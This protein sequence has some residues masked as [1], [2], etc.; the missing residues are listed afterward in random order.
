[1]ATEVSNKDDCKID[2]SS[3]LNSRAAEEEDFP[4][5]GASAL[6][7]LEVRKIRNEAEKDVLFG[8][9]SLNSES[10]PTVK[11]KTKKAKKTVETKKAK[12]DDQPEFLEKPRQ[13]LVES[14]TFKKLYKGMKVLG[15]IKEVNEFDLAI[16]LPN[17]LTGFVSI[18]D[19]NDK[20]TEKLQEELQAKNSED[21]EAYFLELSM[22]FKVGSLVQCSVLKHEVST[23]GHQ[24]IELSLNPKEVNNGLTKLSLKQGMVLQGYVSSVE[25]HGYLISFDIE[26]IKAFLAKKDLSQELKEGHPLCVVIK[27]VAEKN[28]IITVSIDNKE[29]QV[30]MMKEDKSLKFSALLPGMLV[31]A[32]VTQV[33][34]NGLLLNFLGGFEGSADICH[35]PKCGGDGQNLA[36]S[37]PVKAKFKCRL[38]YIN[39][40]TKMAGLSLQGNIIQNQATDFGDFSVGDVVD[41]VTVIRVDQGLGLLMKLSDSVVGFTHI[42]RVSDGHVEK[43]GKEYKVGST[44]RCR[45]LGFN[46]LDGLAILTMERSVIE[47]PFLRYHDIKPGTLVKGKILSLEKYGMLVSV[48]EYIKGLCPTLHL[49][50]ISLKHPEKKLKEGKVVKCRVLSVD[51]N[52]HRLLLTHKKTM[53]DS[54]LP[55]IT[56]Y[57]V[58][59]P[60]VSSHGS[61]YSIKDYGCIVKFY[62]NVKGLVPRS[63]LGIPAD[64][65]PQTAF[66]IGQVVLCHVL[67]SNPDDKRITLSFKSSSNPGPALDY[68]QF[69]G[70]PLEADVVSS[71]SEGLNVILQPSGAPAFLPVSHLSDHPSNCSFLFSLY[72]PSSRLTNVVYYGKRKEKAAIVSLKPSLV[73]AVSEQRLVTNFSDLEVGMILPGVVKNLTNYGI[74]VEFYA[75]VFGLAPNASLSDTFV[76]EPSSHFQTGQTVLA[77][78]TEIKREAKRFLVSLKP[79]E[80]CPVKNEVAI[81]KNG[82]ELLENYLSERTK[83]VQHLASTTEQMKRLITLTPGS[84]VE[85]KVIHVKPHGII[86]QLAEGVQGLVSHQLATGVSCEVGDV[87]FGCA[88]DWDLDKKMVHVSLNPGFVKQQKAAVS[89]PKTKHKL[90]SGREV[91]AIVQLIRKDYIVVMVPQLSYI[92]AYA[93]TR[94]HL[95]DISDASKRF[96][97]G[98]QYNAV[99]QSPGNKDGSVLPLVALIERFEKEKTA[100]GLITTA[101]VKS[102]KDLQ[103]NV[104]LIGRKLHGRV[105]V[106]RVCDELTEGESPLKGFRRGD[107][108]QVK[109]LAFRD[110][111]TRK[112]L[113][114][115]HRNFKK[116]VAELTMKPSDLSASNIEEQGTEDTEEFE[117]DKKLTDYKVGDEVNGFVKEVTNNSVWMVLSPSVKGKVSLLHASS[118]LEVLTSLNTSFKPGYGYKCVVFDADTSREFLELSLTVKPDS[119]IAVGQLIVGRVTKII[120]DQGL[121]VGLPTHKCG[122]VGLTDLSDNYAE[123]PLEGYKVNQLVRCFVLAVKEDDHFDLSL[124]P[125]RTEGSST[126]NEEV[127]DPKKVDKEIK[128]LADL[129]DGDI[130]RGYVKRCSDVGVF[131]SLAHDIDARVQITNLSQYFV[132]QWKLLFPPGKLVTGK[133]LSIDPT[134][135]QVELSL[136]G[137]DVGGP[138]PAPKPKRLEDEER[139]KKERKEQKKKRKKENKEKNES[140]DEAEEILKKLKTDSD[141]ED[142]LESDSEEEEEEPISSSDEEGP[143]HSASQA[144]GLARLQ[145]SSGFDWSEAGETNLSSKRE[146][147]SDKE[148][149]DSETEASAQVARKK[150]K[151]QKRAAKKAEENF[152]YKTEQSLLDQ[153]RLPETAEDFDRL[154]VSSPNNSVVWL[155]YMAYHLHTTDID[156]ARAVGERALKTI[157][158]REE[159]EKLNVWVALMNL[160]NLYGTQESLMK[161]FERALQQN[162]P[163]KVFF[164][165]IGI[166]TR[167]DKMELAEQLY[168]TMIKRFNQSKKV[169][170]GFGSFYM[171]QGKLETGRKLL[172]RSLKSLPKR[173]HIE[174]IVQFAL[175]EFKHGEPQRGQ[176]M[177]ESILTNYPKRSDLWSVYLDMLIKQGEEEPVRQ[178]FERV[179]HI[180][181]SSKKMKLFFKRYLD[182]ERKHGDAISVENVKTKAMEYV[183]SKAALN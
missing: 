5:G 7:P 77:K 179:I 23:S 119:S 43:L 83:I 63:E 40:N 111:K 61:I 129:K 17:G 81:S 89:S 6:T 88:L 41:D 105:H 157:S 8:K 160:E 168:Q 171:K 21:D 182:F 48:S 126:V 93:P 39:A 72:Q 84:D 54:T 175:L 165:L 73:N 66:Y 85:A 34:K 136:K 15:V 107:K 147:E 125:S 97:V 57:S 22:Y 52:W 124:R 139:E 166:Y 140:D 60:G 62:N 56:D 110:Y 167:T 1:M 3:V 162:E 95:N 130:V 46:S 24:R 177:F 32:S 172:Q 183:E 65:E 12:L 102:V 35:L 2:R 158:F 122:R 11:R 49:A 156:K 76:S 50:D 108:V 26:D 55:P 149:G 132:K 135:G 116:V 16:S 134:K 31:K 90:K 104:N 169:W 4:R 145:L 112:Y 27:S 59:S 51:P 151:R 121:L 127:S 87:V 44:H 47:E 19:I 181:L 154:V 91:K 68:N 141:H 106:S 86:L 33:N 82:V 92:L 155:Q 38:L 113:P 153:D 98:R 118:D 37:Y 142:I 42:S 70:V 138:D 9:S 53:V 10:R 71:T 176:T 178:I 173:K 20:V 101:Q 75:G 131:V 99:V 100:P 161:V 150:T 164:Q 29:I 79:S 14:L 180:N 103:M 64:T 115:S 114:I 25:D 67:R 170:I 123:N 174:T 143:E 18:T 30:A 109:V 146:H 144:N 28:R 45:I 133:V 117:Y 96:A 74:F 36:K 58:A 80:C 152:L 163:K 120:P 159:Q 148:S 94:L 137:K 13:R 78:V 128:S 69:A